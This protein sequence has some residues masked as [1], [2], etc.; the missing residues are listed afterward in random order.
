LPTCPAHH[1]DQRY[2]PALCLAVAQSLDLGAVLHGVEGM[3]AEAVV[4]R[5]RELS[6]IAS[7]EV[8]EVWLQAGVAPGGVEW[9]IEQGGVARL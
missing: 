3:D 2:A 7:A 5:W 8:P 6:S 1:S 4:S 9:D